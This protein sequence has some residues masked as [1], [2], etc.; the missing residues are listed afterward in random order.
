M[1]EETKEE[2]EAYDQ[3]VESGN[4]IVDQSKTVEVAADS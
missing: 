2:G 3:P 1:T 4:V